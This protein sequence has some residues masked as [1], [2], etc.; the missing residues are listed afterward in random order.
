MCCDTLCLGVGDASCLIHMIL[1]I[2]HSNFIFFVSFHIFTFGKAF[3]QWCMCFPWRE[4]NLDPKVDDMSGGLSNEAED[5]EFLGVFMGRLVGCSWEVITSVK[6]ILFAGR[7][8]EEPCVVFQCY[9]VT[10]YGNQVLNFNQDFKA[11][12]FRFLAIWVL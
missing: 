11:L 3:K 2:L 10:H 6:W 8:Y 7:G 12:S 5:L 9:E 4:M 1:T